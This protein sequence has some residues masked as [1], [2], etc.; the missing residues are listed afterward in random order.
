M[1]I[2]H[3]GAGRGR[4]EHRHPRLKPIP[5]RSETTVAGEIVIDVAAGGS[6]VPPAPAA[7]SIPS[8]G[9]TP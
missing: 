2:L 6:G 1:N 7:E 8:R 5:G 9:K 4:K 3:R